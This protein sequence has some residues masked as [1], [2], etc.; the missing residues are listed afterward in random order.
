MEG[1]IVTYVAYTN[2]HSENFDAS[3]NEHAKTYK[4]KK[5]D[6]KSKKQILSLLEDYTKI[7]RYNAIR[8]SQVKFELEPENE[9]DENAV[10]VLFRK[11]V[12]GYVPKEHSRMVHDL[13]RDNKNV[14]GT[15]VF[16]DAYYM[17]LDD[18]EELIEEKGDYYHTE[19]YIGVE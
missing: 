3:I 19:L 5:Y 13:I 6:G 9:Y 10:R 14:K 17:T 7:Y 16:S 11:R 12:I 1:N 15:L 18:Y 4:R 2:N 8:T